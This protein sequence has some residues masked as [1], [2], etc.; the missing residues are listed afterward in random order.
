MRV[1]LV[2]LLLMLVFFGVPLFSSNIEIPQSLNA[3]ELGQF[4]G[5]ILNYWQ[6]LWNTAWDQIR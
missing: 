1:F 4:L 6:V 2:I 5:Q 3:K